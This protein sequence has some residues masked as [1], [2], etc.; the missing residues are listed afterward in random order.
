L[1]AYYIK[2]NIKTHTP[3]VAADHYHR[4]KDDLA[5]LGQLGAT[6]YRFSVSWAR[7]LPNC[8][9]QVNE[10]GIKFYANYIDEIRRQGAEPFL[11]MFHWDL[12]QVCW[13]RF[14]GFQSDQIVDAL[15]EYASILFE[16][17]GSKV[18]YW[19]TI[20]EPNAYCN[21]CLHKSIFPP[22][23][24]TSEDTFYACIKRGILAHARIA[25][26]GKSINPTWQFSMPHI[27]EWVE[28]PS[29]YSYLHVQ[30][31]LIFDPCVFGN[32][33]FYV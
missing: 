17:L 10:A 30:T 11:T 29:P 22:H 2:N 16:R 6:A 15:V 27:M 5:F 26:L 13:D 28:P 8:T 18:T 9:G 21:F 32:V 33:R 14:M 12:P 19:L 24:T 3:F 23:T 25:R 7:I 1:L 31:G 4:Y 20:N